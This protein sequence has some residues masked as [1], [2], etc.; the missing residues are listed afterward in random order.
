MSIV[1]TCL[2]EIDGLTD[3]IIDASLLRGANSR[4]AK[5]TMKYRLLAL[6][7]EDIEEN[8]KEIQCSESSIT[9]QFD[10][11]STMDHARGAWDSLSEFLIISSHPGCNDDG[12]R[13][14]YL[15]VRNI[16]HINARLIKLGSPV[17]LTNRIL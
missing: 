4:F 9:V 3:H 6:T 2:D 11:Q 1:C 16:T 7:L 17:P 15:Y 13:A 8:V 14:P 12:E 10:Y 5:T